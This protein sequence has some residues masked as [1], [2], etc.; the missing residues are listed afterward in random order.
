MIR[1]FKDRDT[2]RFFEGHRV[3]AFQGFADQAA[4]RLTL[5][6]SADALQDLAGVAEQSTGG[7]PGRPG[8]AAQHSDQF[9]MAHLLPVGNRRA[10]RRG[11]RGLSLANGQDDGSQER[12][13]SGASGRDPA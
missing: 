4:R 8:R 13:A 12:H 5:L 2:R 1:G 11:D 10:M 9:A 7:A 6:D 3:S